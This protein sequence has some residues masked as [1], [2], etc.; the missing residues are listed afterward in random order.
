MNATD[1]IHDQKTGTI[2][3]LAARMRLARLRLNRPEV[4]RPWTTSELKTLRQMASLGAKAIAEAL[5]RST[6]AV[7][8]QARRQRISLRTQ[9]ERRGK[10]LHQPDGSL[11]GTQL[12]ADVV[13]GI[14]TLDG[15]LLVPPKDLCPSCTQRSIQVI[16]SGLCRPCHLEVLTQRHAM[17]ADQL[18]ADRDRQRRLDAERQRKHRA[19]EV[20]ST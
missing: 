13:A 18:R 15:P 4:V 16:T 9:G 1:G 8:V 17:E 3:D 10:I 7:Q 19:K 6:T 11:R 20:I 12:R 5:D 2:S 14:V